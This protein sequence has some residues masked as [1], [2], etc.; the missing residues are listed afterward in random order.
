MQPAQKN[1][2]GAL[3]LKMREEFLRAGGQQSD[4]TYTGKQ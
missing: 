2:F 4:S 1:M 3:G